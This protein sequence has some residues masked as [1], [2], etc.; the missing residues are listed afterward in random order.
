MSPKRQPTQLKHD[1]DRDIVRELAQLQGCL[2]PSTLARLHY[3]T[4]HVD[5]S[6][7]PLVYSQYV[8]VSRSNRSTPD[9]R[10]AGTDPKP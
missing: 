2:T 7:L 10:R 6:Y 8:T 3:Y 5:P 9:G 1:L 4:T